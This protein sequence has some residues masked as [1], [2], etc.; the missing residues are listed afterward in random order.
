MQRNKNRDIITTGKCCYHQHG[1]Y[2]DHIYDDV[3]TYSRGPRAAYSHNY[4]NV[5]YVTP[6]QGHG[7][8]LPVHATRFNGTPID[9]LRLRQRSSSASPSR[10][11]RGRRELYS[12]NSSKPKDFYRVCG[13]FSDHWKLT[14][15]R[16]SHSS[17]NGSY[18][19]RCIGIAFNDGHAPESNVPLPVPVS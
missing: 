5:P 2:Y 15:L 16:R 8:G 3:H 18:C 4:V 19:L 12:A 10:F 6:F 13:E 14:A 7:Q 17:F 9:V 1:G 11:G